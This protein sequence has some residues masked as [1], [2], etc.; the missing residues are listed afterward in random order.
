MKR[1]KQ[2]CGYVAVIR[3]FRSH[4]ISH[5]PSSSAAF[6][7]GLLTC[8]PPIVQTN[9]NPTHV[10][11]P[12]FCSK[13]GLR[14]PTV[15]GAQDKVGMTQNNSLSADPTWEDWRFGVAVA[16]RPGRR[17]GRHPAASAGGG[18]CGAAGRRA[19][20]RARVLSAVRLGV[21]VQ[22]SSRRE[23]LQKRNSEF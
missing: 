11:H 1:W 13:L 10:P 15:R 5:L 20:T 8:P 6:N 22:C 3:L 19:A 21:T 9:P 7:W 16:G 18:R 17:R 12:I 23:S 4:D 2:V 14:V